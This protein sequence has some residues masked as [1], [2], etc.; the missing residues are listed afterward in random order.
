MNLEIKESD[1]FGYDVLLDGG[2]FR[3]CKTYSELVTTVDSLVKSR[4]NED[5]EGFA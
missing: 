4:F 3:Y 1:N 5:A 2:L